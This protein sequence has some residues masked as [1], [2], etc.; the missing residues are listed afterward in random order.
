MKKTMITMGN[1][2]ETYICRNTNNRNWK[3]AADGIIK[4]TVVPAAVM[5]QVQVQVPEKKAEKPETTTTSETAETA[6]EEKKITIF[7]EDN[8]INVKIMNTIHDLNRRRNNFVE[9]L[10]S[11][12]YVRKMM[13]EKGFHEAISEYMQHG[14]YKYDG[15]VLNYQSFISKINDFNTA[16][17]VIKTAKQEIE[18]LDKE[19]EKYK[20]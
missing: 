3:V 18:K 7:N 19:L 13:I 4:S 9:E 8:T 15:K 2:N 6:A 20:F 5:V 10:S 17:V 1:T 16:C 11:A 12:E 14:G